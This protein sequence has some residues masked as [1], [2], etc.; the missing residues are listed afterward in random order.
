M[1]IGEVGNI[2]PIIQMKKMSKL[3]EIVRRGWKG[4]D[5]MAVG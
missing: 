5:S 1:Y 4:L 2:T 3:L